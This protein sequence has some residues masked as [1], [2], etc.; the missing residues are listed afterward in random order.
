MVIGLPFC[1]QLLLTHQEEQKNL[2][3]HIW[4]F[5]SRDS[6]H[7]C[8][9]AEAEVIQQLF[10][11]D[12]FPKQSSSLNNHLRREYSSCSPLGPEPSHISSHPTFK[13]ETL[14]CPGTRDL[15]THIVPFCPLPVCARGFP[16]S[17]SATL[18]SLRNSCFRCAMPVLP[19][20]VQALASMWHQLK[21]DC[22]SAS[23]PLLPPLS[24][25]CPSYPFI[26]MSA[27][28]PQGQSPGEP[29]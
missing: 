16:A 15:N 8:D 10:L 28:S 4:H 25:C 11:H 20:L 29:S 1:A 17:T 26:P 7:N 22:H 14:S 13:Q 3:H 23:L 6:E 9:K 21:A 5:I 2:P 12:T 19:G 27:A 24:L 18:P